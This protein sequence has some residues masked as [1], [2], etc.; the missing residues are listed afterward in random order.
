MEI[1]FPLGITA[2]SKIGSR[3]AVFN[4]CR[5]VTVV[6]LVG[7]NRQDLHLV[8][9]F[10]LNQG[11][12]GL[13]FLDARAAINVPEVD[14]GNFATII[15]DTYGIIASVNVQKGASVA[16]NDVLATLN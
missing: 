11:E 2:E 13:Q 7:M 1:F 5:N 9:V 15:L 14:N 4:K 16:A 12:F 3:E 10:F 6:F 8:S